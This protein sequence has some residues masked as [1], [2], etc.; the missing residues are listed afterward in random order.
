[1]IN[2]KMKKAVSKV[3]T[4]VLAIAMVMTVV[5]ERPATAAE[6][7][8]SS[9]NENLVL[10]KEARLEDDGTYT[11][12]LEAYA[13]GN[14]T[15]E[16]Y[17]KVV[18][19]DIVLVLD[20]SGSMTQQTI[21]GIPG[22]TYTQVS[23]SLTNA[24]V[25]NGDYYYQAGE[26][27]YP[28]EVKKE[29]IGLKTQWRGQDGK[30]Y[31]DEELSR[32]WF[33]NSDGCEYQT[34]KPFVTSSLET[35]TR[36]HETR[37]LVVNYYYYQ[38]DKSGKTT[39]KE[40][41]ASAAR[42]EFEKS[43]DK[44]NFTIEF[45]SNGAANAGDTDD[46][47]KHY[48]AAVYTTVDPEEVVIYRYTY[49]YTDAEGNTVT[50]G[51]NE[52][53]A[54]GACTIDPLYTR[55][56]TNGYRLD[57]LKYAA[58]KFIANIYAN[59]CKNNVDHRVAVVG[60]ASNEYV[61][62]SKSEYYY[63][64]SELF[65]GA[66]QY[67]YHVDGKE[68]TMSTSGNLAADHYKD[69]FQRILTT[70]GHENLLASIDNLSGKGSTYPSIGFEM[71][72]GIFGANSDQ[73]TMD[74]GTMGTRSRIIIFLTDGTPGRYS[75]DFENNVDA[76]DKEATNT[77]NKA[78]TSKTTYSAKVYT[79]AV[80]DQTPTVGSK[81]D[82]FLKDVSSSNE[83]T[84]A[85]DTAHLENFFNQ[86]D[87]SIS[88]PTTTV[89]L[90]E[91]A[92]LADVLSDDFVV[93]EDF[94]VENNVTVKTAKHKGNEA[95]EAPIDAPAGVT[96]AEIKDTATGDV[97]GIQVNGFN[98]VSTE[99]M[100]I[101][102]SD[103]GSTGGTGNKLIVTIKGL[104]AKD[105]AATGTYIPTNKENSAIW[106]KD[107]D[108]ASDDYVIVK[109]FNV[110]RTMLD[111]KMVVL[112]YAK[113]AK[114]DA[115]NATKVDSAEDNL[116]SKVGTESVS[117]TEKY[118]KVNVTSDDGLTYT[119]STMQWDGYDS[120]YAL[121]KDN[122]YGDQKTK[123]IWSKVTVVP[124]NNVYYEDDFVTDETNGT[125]G[126]VY[127]GNWN[128]EGTSS[129]NQETA[130]TG[131]H[132]GWENEDLADDTTFTDGTA[133]VSSTSGATAT[134]TF[135]GKGVD[136]YSYTDIKSGEIRA[137]LYRINE[138]GE[139]PTS[140]LLKS[141]II[142]NY[143]ASGEYYQIPTASFMDLEYGTYKVEIKV[144]AKTTE[145]GTRSTYYL[146]GIR[147]Y[148]PVAEDSLVQEA[149]GDE[150]SAVFKSVR[151]I[152]LD[153]RKLTADET[154]A[155]GVV[156][157]DQQDNSTGIETNVIG[158]YEEI[159]PKNEVYL[160]A[161]QAIAFKVNS[162]NT[163]SYSVGLKAMTGSETIATVTNAEG[164]SEYPIKATSDLYYELIPNENGLIVIKNTGDD[165]LSV[166]K[167]KT[168]AAT[169]D[170]V[171]EVD[172]AMLMAYV[173]EFDTLEVIDVE[174]NPGEDQAPDV[175]IKDDTTDNDD[176]QQDDTMSS[177][178]EIVKEII[179][180]LRGWFG[181]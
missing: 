68:S 36:H 108:A 70:E 141:Y 180:N 156:F 52:N 179:K 29:A 39:S 121:G 154:T 158:T 103:G 129:N 98:Y 5:P 152:L 33:R 138:N 65:V 175:E 74:D 14:V 47:D 55:D 64:N 23:G 136:I 137:K 53:N 73:Y 3:L 151:E 120:F 176:V 49:S 160:A 167:L 109:A 19:A 69:A 13:K 100:V 116:F 82:Q 43:I 107:N 51:S 140:T 89:T 166:T 37:Y 41:S 78:N 135:K 76:A 32:S 22:N 88:N 119:P 18:P 85:T 8:T 150:A 161:G 168:C 92:V 87:Q 165:L 106:D 145:A 170:P 44:N 38:E 46:D 30:I 6:T 57:A 2:M 97:K 162:S 115:Y 66:T 128:I 48:V 102:N 130:N 75:T 17:K 50:I 56:T 11:I 9:G 142:D 15:T 99:N 127:N 90:T 71:A 24:Q 84:L 124:A 172:M 163:A 174:E 164:V 35:Y 148:N 45:H 123:N 126:I 63:S 122:T 34:A 133:H 147:I 60:F 117:L 134:F 94:S 21:S 132:G 96:A 67:N 104:L 101:T 7:S 42:E 143:A 139:E 93:P 4:A 181:H 58:N 28:V 10:N 25:E 105:E 144:F 26:N 20:Q 31:K 169:G 95:F 149:Y 113:T 112:D 27:Y 79:V 91:N 146:D 12:Q 177:L 111:K 54:E 131:I 178:Q 171:E 1:M 83:Y 72:N 59:A 159:G 86:I 80:L 153:A 77:K 173:N 125:V 61:D 157:I 118:G 114:I 40:S 16:T 81:V 155:D 62:G 110:P